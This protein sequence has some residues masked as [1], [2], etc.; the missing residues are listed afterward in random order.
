MKTI[1]KTFRILFVLI[2]LFFYCGVNIFTTDEE[3]KFGENLSKEI[4]KQ[5]KVVTEGEV[6]EYVNSLGKKVETICDRKD[7]KYRFHVID[8]S[9]SV[10]AFALPGGYIYVYTGLLLNLDNEAELAG[11]LA[12][13]V[14]HVVA[15]HSMK[16]L[17]QIYGYSLISGILLGKDPA[18][19]QKL[20]GNL[21]TSMGILAYS[22]ENEYEADSY[23]IKYMNTLNYDPA[24][25]T[26]VFEKFKTLQTREPGSMEKL[27][28]THPTPSDRIANAKTLIAGITLNSSLIKN[29][30][31]YLSIKSKITKSKAKK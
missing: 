27:L 8:D 16:K 26:G 13:E 10:N 11:I 3:V 20:A 17:T 5:N 15:H 2:F 6:F 19:W 21:F 9:A 30:E 23:A 22:R 25:M 31:Q 14:G 4:S 24:E 7:I 18:F 28:S 1:N 29:E 12:H